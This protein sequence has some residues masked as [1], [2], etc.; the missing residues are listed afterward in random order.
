MSIVPDAGTSSQ[1]RMYPLHKLASDCMFLT[2]Q[3]LSG[4]TTVL[5]ANF[6]SKELSYFFG[7]KGRMLIR[8]MI[9]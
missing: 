4:A 3:Q 1:S 2:D 7:C 5:A 9:S 6:L 8:C